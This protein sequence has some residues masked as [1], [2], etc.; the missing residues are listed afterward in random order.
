[1]GEKTMEIKKKQSPKTTYH[2]PEVHDYHQPQ[3]RDYGNIKDITMTKT[4]A[5]S[6]K[7]GSWHKSGT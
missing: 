2:Q 1:M 5:S 4:A 7:D 3:V 6:T